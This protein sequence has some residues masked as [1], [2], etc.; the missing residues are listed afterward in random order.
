MESLTEC[1]KGIMKMNSFVNKFDFLVF[2]LIS[3][4]VKSHNTEF[5]ALKFEAL[6]NI[7]ADSQAPLIQNEIKSLRLKGTY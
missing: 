4:H 6:V 2:T 3:F 7:E 1:L 5:P